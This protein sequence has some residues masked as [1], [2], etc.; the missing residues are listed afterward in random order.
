MNNLINIF[1]ELG[2]FNRDIFDHVQSYLHQYYIF[3]HSSLEDC[4]KKREPSLKRKIIYYLSIVIIIIQTINLGIIIKYPDHNTQVL[5]GDPVFLFITRHQLFNGLW[6]CF[7]LMILLVKLTLL[8]YEMTNNNFSKQFHDVFNGSGFFKLTKQHE[9]NILLVA[10]IFYWLLLRFCHIWFIIIF[11]STYTMFGIVAYFIS[12]FRFDIITLA[13][14]TIQKTANFVILISFSYGGITLF[15]IL[16]TF[17]IL[18]IN[19]IT[20]SIKIVTRW[21]NK[22][23]IIQQIAQYDKFNKVF[24]QINTPIDII[25]SVCYMTLPYLS[26]TLVEILKWKTPTLFDISVKLLMM[27]IFIFCLLNLSIVNTVTRMLTLRN[28]SI[29]RYFYRFIAKNNFNSKVKPQYFSFTKQINNIKLSMKIHSFI[30]R[31]RYDHL[32]FY[33]FNLMSFSMKFI[34]FSKRLNPIN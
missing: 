34:R 23:K 5:L 1:G 3:Y 14:I 2:T 22:N 26:S 19:E 17:L 29:P 33:V 28:N 20:K 32:G 25:I 6:F 13:V 21:Q 24:H 30:V 15:Y 18:K 27:S 11:L 12:P 7:N 9:V 4:I 16:I 10:N 8:Y 31:F